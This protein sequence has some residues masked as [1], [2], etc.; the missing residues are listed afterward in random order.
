MEPIEDLLSRKPQDDV[1]TFLATIADSIEEIINF[2]THVFEWFEEGVAGRGDE[3]API[4]MSFK[5]FL[6]MLDAISAL[7]RISIVEPSKIQLRSALEASMSIAWILQE[8]SERRAMAFMVWNVHEELKWNHKFDEKTPQG[9]ELKQKLK[10]TAIENTQLPPSANIENAR[11]N[12]NTLLTRPKYHAAEEEYQRLRKEKIKNPN[13]YSFFGGPRN[14]EQLATKVGMTEWYELLYRQWSGVVHATDLLVGKVA[15]SEGKTYIQKMRYPGEVETVYTLTVSMA[16]KTYKRILEIFI[17][18][19]L[20]VFADWY[21][22]EV[23][24]LYMRL[25]SGNPVIVAKAL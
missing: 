15:T 14:V 20:E 21:V 19:K 11:Q 9:K 24:D 17:P 5:Q 23:R 12:L 2:G 7:V 1:S 25:S 13:W 3:V 10:D 18:S 22:S 4:A 8:D 16:L 6:E